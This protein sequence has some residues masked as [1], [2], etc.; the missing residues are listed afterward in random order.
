MS[1]EH[2][3]SAAADGSVTGSAGPVDPVNGGP[4]R[5]DSPEELMRRDGS[6]A[7]NLVDRPD[8]EPRVQLQR[9][10]EL[11]HRLKQNPTDREAFLELG[12]IYRAEQ[13]PAD[14]RRI[15]QQA[16]EIF[17][18]DAELIWEREEA[19]LARSLQQLREVIDLTR[20]LDT[21]ETQR[22][23]ERS[24]SDWAARRIEVCRARLQR[25][26]S[27]VHLRI[28]LA[29][30]LYDAGRYDE[31]LETVEPMLENDQHSPAAFLIRGR[32]SLER[33]QELEAMAALRAASLR[34]A[35]V[36]PLP[37]R[38]AALRFLCETAERLGL[39]LTLTQYRGFLAQAEQELAAKHPSHPSS[40]NGL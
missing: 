36:A 21:P 30:A 8:A 19:A 18:D 7:G 2:D 38:I 4:W 27:L 12:R 34:R 37:T 10:Q 23:L 29:E 14:A 5:S 28:P 17:A 11:E 32:C 24:H 40:E 1:T 3:P 25:D 33:K 22:E 26:A 39:T 9:R 13:R 35:V 16:T 20:R 15:L 31:A 6:A